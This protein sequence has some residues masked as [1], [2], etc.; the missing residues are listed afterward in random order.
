[1]PVEQL[2]RDGRAQRRTSA[3]ARIRCG[4]LASDAM[5]VK[6]AAQERQTQ[7]A[8]R[9]RVAC[10][11]PRPRDLRA[12]EHQVEGGGVNDSCCSYA[13][14]RV[15]ASDET[16]GRMAIPTK[17]PRLAGPW[18]VLLRSAGRR[19]PTCSLMVV[20]APAAGAIWPGTPRRTLISTPGYESHGRLRGYRPRL[21][22][23]RSSPGCSF[24][25]GFWSIPPL[26]PYPVR[27]KRPG[28]TPLR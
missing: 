3:S 6:P 26:R 12:T 24:W 8:A 16:R 20:A 14:H 23:I 15:F 25:Q 1:M 7:T 19:L 11:T 13:A 21:R 4:T 5:R 17:S 2:R 18:I 22:T 27:V 9:D 10:F 28:T